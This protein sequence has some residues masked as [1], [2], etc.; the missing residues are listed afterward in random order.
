L[1]LSLKEI[2]NAEVGMRR[3]ELLEDVFHHG[4]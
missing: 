2:V 3:L 4:G 1:N